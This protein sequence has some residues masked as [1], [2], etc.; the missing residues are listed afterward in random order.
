[1][2]ICTVPTYEDTVVECRCD[3]E[4]VAASGGNRHAGVVF[5]LVWITKTHPRAKDCNFSRS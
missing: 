4:S 2:I 1:M 5:L 3:L